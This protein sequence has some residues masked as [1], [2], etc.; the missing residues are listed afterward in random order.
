V[1]EAAGYNLVEL[2]GADG[3][4]ASDLVTW[5]ERV[6]RSN[7]TAERR[8]A[9]F[10]DDFESFTPE[11]RRKLARTLSLKNTH[12][13]P[14]IVTCNDPKDLSMRDTLSKFSTVRLFPPREQTCR[15]WFLEHHLWTDSDQVVHH[16]LPA[17]V[18]CAEGALLATGD[19]RACALA[20]EW[21]ARMEG[22]AT[23]DHDARSTNRFDLARSVLGKRGTPG[24]WADRAEDWDVHLLQ[25]H[26][27]STATSLETLCTELDAFSEMD[28]CRTHDYSVGGVL[29]ARSVAVIEDAV[30]LDR[31]R[32]SSLTNPARGAGGLAPPPRS[33]TCPAAAEST[34]EP[35]KTRREM[36]DVPSLLRDPR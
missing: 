1:V 24:V 20:M 16:G 35:P 32:S 26:T 6:R 5:V 4:S 21:R 8:A 22:H 17:N 18:V 36:L 29:R 25:Y 15:H 7:T 14:A 23:S 13:A 27:A 34:T 9:I 2:D 11:T 3:E 30:R 12:F 33:R 10:L 19:L 28:V 31:N